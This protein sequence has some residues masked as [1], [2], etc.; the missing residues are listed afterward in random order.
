MMVIF[1]IGTPLL[2]YVLLW[3][4]REAIETRKSRRGGKELDSL[5]FLFKLYAPTHWRFSLLDMW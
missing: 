3:Y 1:P 2:M 4:Q 5:S